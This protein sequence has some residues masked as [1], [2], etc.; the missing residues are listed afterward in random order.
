MDYR[1]HKLLKIAIKDQRLTMAQLLKEILRSATII[2]GSSLLYPPITQSFMIGPKYSFFTVMAA[3]IQEH[4]KIQSH[5]KIP[6]STSEGTII[7]W[8]YSILWTSNSISIMEIPSLSQV[9]RLA[10]Q[11]LFSMLII[12][13][14]IQKHL[15]YW[16]YLIVVYS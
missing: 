16:L 14:R 15:R 1:L 7:Q 5:T 10:G 12:F 4:E 11:L 13:F 3:S 8:N 6:N 2:M 9:F